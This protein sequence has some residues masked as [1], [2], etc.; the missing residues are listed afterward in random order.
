MSERSSCTCFEPAS[1]TNSFISEGPQRRRISRSIGFNGFRDAACRLAILHGDQAR[2]LF[3]GR[4][5]GLATGVD[6]CNLDSGIVESARDDADSKEGHAGEVPAQ[7][8]GKSKSD[9]P[10]AWRMRMLRLRGWRRWAA[11]SRGRVSSSKSETASRGGARSRADNPW[12]SPND[13]PGHY[14]NYR[15]CIA[16]TIQRLRYQMYL[17]KPI[18]AETRW[19]TR[20]GRCMFGE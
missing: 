3:S 4:R 7:S 15:G 2:S 16:L 11:C 9:A 13:A 18:S 14:E 17:S 1:I 5:S 6:P 10:N 12:S 8:V 20:N 19:P